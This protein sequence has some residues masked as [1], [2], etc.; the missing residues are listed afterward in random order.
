MQWDIIMLRVG[1]INN[2]R[3]RVFICVSTYM[4]VLC[5][6]ITHRERDKTLYLN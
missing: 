1:M 4:R 3:E 2:H 5:I 6:L